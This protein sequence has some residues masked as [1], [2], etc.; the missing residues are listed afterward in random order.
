MKGNVL[1]LSYPRSGN[2]WI[3]YI[4]EF[5]TRSNTQ[6]MANRKGF[7]GPSIKKV[8]KPFVYK[9]HFVSD[10]RKLKPETFDRMIL[11]VRNYKEVIVRHHGKCR[12]NPN[13][14]KSMF[15]VYFD[16]IKYYDNFEGD[17]MVI[18]YEDVVMDVNSVV[19][20]LKNFFDVSDDIV[21]D[22]LNDISNHTS[23]S[24]KDYEKSNESVTK[25]NSLNFHMKKITDNV[26]KAIED[27]EN[28]HSDNHIIQRYIGE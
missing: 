11:V 28:K 16:D 10:I 3:R 6:D 27:I 7:R 12:S 4:I 14:W 9:R 2:S 15:E 5:L 24:I 1:L 26:W 8:N 23:S 25:G 17:K 19:V 13:L 18:Y 22:F 21:N 20:Q